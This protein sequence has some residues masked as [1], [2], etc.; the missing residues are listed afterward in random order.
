MKN[1][2]SSIIFLCW[3]P[4]FAQEQFINTSFGTDGYLCISGLDQTDIMGEV[5]KIDDYYYALTG[6]I[7]YYIVK[8]DNNG[9]LV[10]GFGNNGIVDTNLN[11]SFS[12]SA[13][14]TDAFIKHTPDNKLLVVVNPDMFELNSFMAKFDL[15]GDL[16]T[17]FGDNGYVLPFN[18]YMMELSTVALIDDGI[19][20][21][22][23][24]RSQ[25]NIDE[26]FILIFKYDYNGNVITDF[27]IDGAIRQDLDNDSYAVASQFHAA[28]NSIYSTTYR[29][30]DPFIQISR[31]DLNAEIFDTNF[32]NDGY[33]IPEI[34]GQNIINADFFVDEDENVYTT[35]SAVNPEMDRYL[36]IRKYNSSLQLDPDFGDSGIKQIN[37]TDNSYEHVWSINIDSNGIL[38]TG[39]VAEY[40]PPFDY[41]RIVLVKLDE[42]GNFNEDFGQGGII[43]NTLFTT[44]NRP[45][46][47]I[48]ENGI[49]TIATNSITCEEFNTPT[50]IQINSNGQV[51]VEDFDNNA[52]T[53]Y[54]NPFKDTI[55]LDNASNIAS[56]ELYDISGKLLGSFSKPESN[57]NLSHLQQGVYLLKITT[58]VGASTRKI[59]KQ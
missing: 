3:I 29:S 39:V 34:T 44:Y 37:I 51:S 38:L 35:G 16:D 41:E 47:T 1:I 8:F 21:V 33:F 50:V 58:D 55:S 53:L 25:L 27:G 12:S 23:Q 5:I 10:S 57:L 30:S 15:D 49:L 36:F 13:Y 18:E 11:F 54:P 2:I 26:N 40:D 19:I 48:E 22:G 32:G 17:S 7:N 52:I 45:Y 4:G 43:I 42:N 6:E 20:I 31:F 24:N 28:A 46:T 14:N 56:I 9:Q 59:V